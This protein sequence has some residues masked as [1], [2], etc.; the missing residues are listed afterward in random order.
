[1]KNL[2]DDWSIRL[3]MNSSDQTLTHFASM[4]I[5]H[6]AVTYKRREQYPCFLCAIFL[7]IY[8]IISLEF[9]RNIK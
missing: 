8:S 2:H 1:M 7:F 6:K 9:S 3:G 5:P 4:L